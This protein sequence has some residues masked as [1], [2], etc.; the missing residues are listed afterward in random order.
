[1]FFFNKPKWICNITTCDATRTRCAER[2][3]TKKFI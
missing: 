2:N 3:N 1:M